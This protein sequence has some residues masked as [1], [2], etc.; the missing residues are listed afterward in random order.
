LNELIIS[1]IS[2]ISEDSRF[3]KMTASE[4]AKLQIR[5]DEILVMDVLDTSVIE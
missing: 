1:T 3:A 4:A 5:V 2:A